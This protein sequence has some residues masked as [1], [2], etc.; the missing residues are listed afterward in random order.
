MSTFYIVTKWTNLNC[1]IHVVGRQLL[2]VL[3]SKEHMLACSWAQVT[4]AGTVCSHADVS[5]ALLFLICGN[6]VYL[7]SVCV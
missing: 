3:K 5:S 2:V 4:S 1:G 7:S 6:A